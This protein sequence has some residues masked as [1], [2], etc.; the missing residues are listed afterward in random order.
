VTEN[1]EIKVARLETDIA[2]IKKSLDCNNEKTEDILEKITRLDEKINNHLQHMDNRVQ[3]I[4]SWKNEQCKKEDKKD[5]W[6]MRKTALIITAIF[7][8]I[9]VLV[10]I[11]TEFI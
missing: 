8:A 4:E 9:T 5:E 10:A 7:S 11:I 6:S 1:I 2:Y 3:E